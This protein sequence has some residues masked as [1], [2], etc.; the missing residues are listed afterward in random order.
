MSWHSSAGGR[1]VGRQQRSVLLLVLTGA[2]AAEMLRFL[3]V[4][5]AT[6]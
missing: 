6:G 3:V 1:A 5:E 4:G 2:A